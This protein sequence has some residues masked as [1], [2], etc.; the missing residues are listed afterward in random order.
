[1]INLIVYEHYSQ[2][3]KFWLEWSSYHLRVFIGSNQ[4]EVIGTDPIQST[5]GCWI[6][7]TSPIQLSI[8]TWTER[9]QLDIVLDRFYPLDI[10]IGLIHWLS[11]IQPI[12]NHFYRITKYNYGN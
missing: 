3:Y 7:S 6:F 8:K 10:L 12:I 2:N 9:I 4:M 5:I 11:I 1:M